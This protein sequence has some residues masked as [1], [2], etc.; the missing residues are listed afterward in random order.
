MRLRSLVLVDVRNV[1]L[2]DA[3]AALAA[4]AKELKKR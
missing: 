1:P 4:I 2:A 3:R